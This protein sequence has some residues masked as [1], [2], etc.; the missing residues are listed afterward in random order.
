MILWERTAVKE[1][2]KS[3]TMADFFNQEEFYLSSLALHTGAFHDFP[4][5]RGG[6]YHLRRC[7]KLCRPAAFFAIRECGSSVHPT[8][9]TVGIPPNYVAST[10]NLRPLLS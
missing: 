6:S 9:A 5:A 8:R 4:K 1:F 10:G 7:H 2:F 3:A